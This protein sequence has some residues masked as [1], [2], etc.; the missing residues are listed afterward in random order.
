M[1]CRRLGEEKSRTHLLSFFSQAVTSR[2]SQLPM[3]ISSVAVE[4]DWFSEIQEG[5]QGAALFIIAYIGFYGLSI[6][7]LFA[8]QL[9]ET[10]KER[11]ELPAYFLKTLWDVPNKN[12][13]YRSYSLGELVR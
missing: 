10:Q 11:Q 3:N 12:K 4:S 2:V 7:C 8:Q 13:L 5:N 6:I 9:K 1:R